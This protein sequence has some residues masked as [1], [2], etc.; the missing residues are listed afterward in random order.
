VNFGTL[1]TFRTC[2]T[3]AF[4]PISRRDPHSPTSPLQQGYAFGERQIFR[5]A[6]GVVQTT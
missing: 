6:L 3:H 1:K 2:G 5:G 4:L